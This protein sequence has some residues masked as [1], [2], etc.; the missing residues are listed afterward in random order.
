MT[1]LEIADDPAQFTAALDALPNSPAV[2]VL[3]PHEGRP[4]LSKTTVLRRRLQRLRKMWNLDRTLARIEYW[5]TASGLESSV[6]QYEQARRLMPADYLDV[7]RL[8]M[9]PYVK[10]VLANQFPRSH[11]TTHLVRSQA[12]FYG[13]FRSRAAAERFESQFLDLFQMRRCQEDLT[14]SPAHPGCIYG[15]MAMCLRPCQEVVGT[16]EYSREVDRVVDFLR[17]DGN[18]LLEGI[19]RSRDRLS[20]EMMFEDAAR[21]HKRFEKVQEV[22]KLRDDLAHDVDHLSGVAIT[23]STSADAVQM[24][25]VQGGNWME[26]QRFGFE[27]LEGRPAPL[28]RKLRECFASVKPCRLTVRERQEYLAILARWYYSSWREGEWVGFANFD[29]IPYRKVVNAVSRVAR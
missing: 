5:L 9:P 22:L 23:A 24:W 6:I 28:D 1:V 20:E 16:A 26:P 19:G 25:F 7:L 15:E 3:W 27:V 2:F 17:S 14:P 4:H 21:Q 8:R 10:V 13:P 11:I 29:E 18:S 12:L